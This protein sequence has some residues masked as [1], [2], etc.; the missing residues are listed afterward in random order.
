MSRVVMPRAYIETIYIEGKKEVLGLWAAQ[1]EGAK[2]QL[3]F[4][5]ADRSSVNSTGQITC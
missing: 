4:L 5:K 2:C 1:N 3:R